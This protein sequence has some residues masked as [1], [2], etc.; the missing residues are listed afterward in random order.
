M[1]NFKDKTNNSLLSNINNNGDNNEEKNIYK[2]G[3]E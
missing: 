3:C 1:R 2:H